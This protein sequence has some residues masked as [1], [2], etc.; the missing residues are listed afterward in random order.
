MQKI[1]RV[2]EMQRIERQADAQ[3]LSFAQMMEN[4][5]KALAGVVDD[6]YGYLDEGGALGLVGSGNNG[7]DTL[8]ALAHLAA[9]GWKATAYLVRPRPADDPLVRRVEQAGG[10]VYA[11]ADDPDYGRLRLLLGEHAMLLDGILGTGIQLPLRGAVA[12]VLAETGAFRRVQHR[13]EFVVAVDCPSGVDCDTGQVANET[14]P[15]DLTVCMAAIKIGLLN[16]PARRA[17]GEIALVPI[18]LPDDLPAWTAVQRRVAEPELVRAW[19]PARPE[20]AHKGTFG[21]ALVCAGSLSYSGAALLA[22]RAA[23]RVGAGLVTLAIPAGLHL[24]LAGQF[25]EATWT[26]LP[27]AQ[28]VIGAEAAGRLRQAAEKASALLIGPG[29]GLEAPVR[30]F[31][32]ALFGEP[33]A[34][35]KGLPPLVID[36]DGLKLL[37]DIENWHTRLPALAVLTPHPGEMAILTGLSKAEI[38]ADRLATAEQYAR[39]WGQVVVLKGAQTLVAAPDGRTL[40]IPVATAALARAGSGDVLAGIITGLLAQGVAPFEAAGLGAWLH[41]QAG[42]RAEARLGAASVLAGDLI[43]ELPGVLQNLNI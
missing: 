15:A 41:G 24:A 14:L 29:F 21:T 9:D 7:G 2:A 12:E 13:P 17:C 3:G 25:P 37:A 32:Q 42:L 4:A 40:L 26:L 16:F 19:L 38:Q 8:V 23:Y 5:G 6:Q 22:G 35:S 33:A 36:A 31:M 28:G 27:E 34:E 30:G 20:D 1:V 39:R 11:A 43:D 18:G 10:Q